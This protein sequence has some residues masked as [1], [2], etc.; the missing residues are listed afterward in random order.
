MSRTQKER[1]TYWWVYVQ[2]QM[3]GILHVGKAIFFWESKEHKHLH[4]LMWQCNSTSPSCYSTFCETTWKVAVKCGRGKLTLERH[5]SLVWQH[6]MKMFQFMKKAPCWYFDEVVWNKNDQSIWGKDD[7]CL[8][9]NFYDMERYLQHCSDFQ[10]LKVKETL[11]FDNTLYSFCC[12]NVINVA[13]K[14]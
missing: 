8:Q 6:I 12:T 11:A 2:H 4:E 13:I 1:K 5:P 14:A 7:K 3:K 9:R 10:L